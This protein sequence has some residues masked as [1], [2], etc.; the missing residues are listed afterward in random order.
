MKVEDDIGKCAP[1]VEAYRDLHSTL[2]VNLLG[3]LVSQL[4][5]HS[6]CIWLAAIALLCY[7]ERDV[8]EYMLY[9][10]LQSTA[11]HYWSDDGGVL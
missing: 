3:G 11:C 9:C 1:L 2:C 6:H 8:V 7:V 10:T 5:D 4:P